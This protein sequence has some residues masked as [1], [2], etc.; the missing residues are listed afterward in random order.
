MHRVQFVGLVLIMGTLILFRFGRGHL[1]NEAEKHPTNRSSCYYHHYYHH[2]HDFFVH[3]KTTNIF[4]FFFK[5]YFLKNR[6]RIERHAR[7]RAVVLKQL[8][9]HESD[10]SFRW[11][12]VKQAQSINVFLW[13]QQSPCAS[14]IFT[15]HLCTVDSRPSFKCQIQTWLGLDLQPFSRGLVSHLR[16]RVTASAGGSLDAISAG[17]LAVCALPVLGMCCC[18]THV[19]ILASQGLCF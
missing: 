8:V 13:V 16:L 14:S 7:Q 18:V 9:S 10:R 1:S 17:S 4:F 11:T 6:C 5:G 15:L 3:E 2:P 12:A 19:V